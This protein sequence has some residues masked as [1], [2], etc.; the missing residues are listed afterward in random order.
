MHLLPLFC[1]FTASKGPFILSHVVTVRLLTLKLLLKWLVLIRASFFFSYH[2]EIDN[3]SFLPRVDLRFDELP[4]PISLED[5]T[6]EDDAANTAENKQKK[7]IIK[8]TP[9]NESRINFNHSCSL[10][11]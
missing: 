5:K 7:T 11:V 2:L 9:I 3:S 1:S 8:R 6:G 10:V 4:I